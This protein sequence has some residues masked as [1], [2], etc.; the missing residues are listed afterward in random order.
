MKRF[1]IELPHDPEGVACARFVKLALTSG[2]HVL[3][4][5]DWGCE[6]GVHNGWVIIEAESKEEARLALPPQMRRDATIVALNYFS[7]QQIDAFLG[8]HGS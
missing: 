8:S 4:H 3:T 1:L 5:A 6:D 2:S 7:L